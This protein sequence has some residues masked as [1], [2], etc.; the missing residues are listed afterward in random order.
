MAAV[1]KEGLRFHLLPDC[2]TGAA[3][4]VSVSFFRHT[5]SA[6]LIR[7]STAYWPLS[8]RLGENFCQQKVADAGFQISQV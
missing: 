6:A 1:H 5:M 2:T 4:F 3:T 8:R 7:H